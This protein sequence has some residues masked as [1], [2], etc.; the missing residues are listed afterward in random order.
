MSETKT[1]PNIAANAATAP[2][3]GRRRRAGTSLPDPETVAALGAEDESGID[4]GPAI[5]ALDDLLGWAFELARKD[6]DGWPE[7]T[8]RIRNAHRFVRAVLRGK[9]PRTEPREDLL[10]TAALLVRVFEGDLGLAVDQVASVLDQLGLPLDHVPV[11]HAV[12]AASAP[13]PIAPS[14]WRHLRAIHARLTP[15]EAAAARDEAVILSAARRQVW[16]A[17]LS[18][19]TVDDG[20]D[21]VRAYLRGEIELPRQRASAPRSNAPHVV[22]GV[23][24][25][26]AG[27]RVANARGASCGCGLVP[28][29]F[30]R[31]A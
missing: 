6:V 1:T 9:T 18:R 13:S 3:L 31:T 10:F 4:Y 2:K 17:E 21:L 29:C 11:T 24:T 26:F 23:P 7:G 5:E 14:T 27:A 30:R 25:S 8:R 20:V 28:S 19:R 22:V 15:A 12:P 16:I